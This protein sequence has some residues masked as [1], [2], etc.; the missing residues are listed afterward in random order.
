MNFRKIKRVVK[1]HFIRL[2]R[3]KS[4]AKQVAFGFSLGFIPNWFPTFGL[5]PII[6]VAISK[7]LKANLVAAII[8][9][10]SGAFIWPF[11]FY[12]N[13]KVGKFLV[14]L[15]THIASIEENN[16]ESV[17]LFYYKTKT[18]GIEFILGALVNCLTFGLISYFLLYFILTRHRHF[19][20][21]ILKKW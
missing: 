11:L 5:G 18:I 2:F 6:S 4:G 8:G 7:P 19:Y 13:L 3:I 21:R 16:I 14:H 1:Y 20:L 12:L 10:V 17:K 9:G 15:G